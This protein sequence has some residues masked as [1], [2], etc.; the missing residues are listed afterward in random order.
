MQ[1]NG[2]NDPCAAH[3]LLNSY[4]R[5]QFLEVSMGRR[6]KVLA[7]FLAIQGCSQGMRERLR[8]L[9]ATVRYADE[10]SGYALVWISK[11]KLLD[12][13]DLPGIEYAYTRDD[14]RLYHQDPI[15]KIPLGD[16]RAEPL[17][18]VTIPYPHVATIRP[19]GGPYFAKHDIGLTELWKEHPEADGRGV[20]VAVSDGGFDLLHPA[21]QQARDAVGNI[22]PKIADLE[23]LTSPE[24]DSG[25]VP[26]G[27]PIRT[28]N[29]NF[30]AAGRTWTVPED[31]LYRFGIFKTELMLGPEDNSHVKRLSF[32]VGVLWSPQSQRVWVD[33]D[34]DG[35]FKNQRALGDYGATFDVDWFG[36][37]EGDHDN[38]I[39]FGVKIDTAESAVY[40]RI[41]DDHGT[42]VGGPL[43]S[44]RL[45]GGLFDGA[46]PSTQ[47][48]DDN[49]TGVTK[50][51]SIVPSSPL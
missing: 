14:D 17:P 3:V 25:W 26:F 12:T 33:T 27:E 8:D 42:L 18:A 6:A 43:A 44:N 22:V 15:A 21:L 41:G 31:G 1:I 20:R 34:G 11:A 13:L 32:S 39:P 37:K 7:E 16:R 10:Q 48:V 19:P 30:E 5:M 50:V 9:G 2:Q 35:S 29:G 36:A 4:E 24:E 45:T 28:K 23:T 46:A 51:A 38:R 49:I 40:I 47:L